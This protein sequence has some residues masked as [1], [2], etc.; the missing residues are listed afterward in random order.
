MQAWIDKTKLALADNTRPVD[1]SSAEELLKKHYELNDDISG[2]K[3]EFEYVRDLG[4]R[5]LHKNPALNDVCFL[6]WL[7]YLLF[8]TRSDWDCQRTLKLQDL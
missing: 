4:R 8:N 2:K 7:F 6:N 1:V 3:Y 5:L